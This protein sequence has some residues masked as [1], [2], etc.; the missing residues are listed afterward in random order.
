MTET[1]ERRV[2]KEKQVKNEKVATEKERQICAKESDRH[3][4][5]EQWGGGYTRKRKGERDGRTEKSEI[6]ERQRK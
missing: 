4:V 6:N 1:E 2:E 5:G 3:C